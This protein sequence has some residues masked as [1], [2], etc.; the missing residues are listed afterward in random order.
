MKEVFRNIFYMSRR[1]KLPSAL[2]LI[3]LVIAYAAFYLLMTQVIYESTYNHSIKDYKRLYRMESDFVYNEW[4]FS[5]FVCRPFADALQRMPEVE[6]YSLVHGGSSNESFYTLD[7]LRHKG[8]TVHYAMSPA[9]NTALSTLSPKVLDGEI[10]WTDTNKGTLIIP[11]SVATDYFGTE[12]AKDKKMWLIQNE[13]PVSFKVRGV[14]EDFPENSELLRRIYYNIYDEDTLELNAGYKCIV[15]FKDVPTDKEMK[16]LSQSLKQAII[17]HVS[18]GLKKKGLESKIDTYI[19]EINKTNFRFVPLAE[20]YFENTSF[21]SSGVRGFKGMLYILV[22]TCLIVIIIAAINFLN[23]TLV[24]SPMRISSLNTR[25]VLGAS[26]RSLRRI[27]VGEGIVISLVAC[28]AAIILCGLIQ[29][30]PGANK[31]ADGNLSLLSHWSL[32]V[33]MLGLAI[34]VGVA[35][36]HYPSIYATSYPTAIVLKGS[37]GLT[38]RG[39]KLRQVLTVFQLCISMLMVIYVGILL[40]QTRFILQSEYGYNKDNV[41]STE[42]P[43]AYDYCAENDTVS[44]LLKR[45]PVV[46]DVAFSDNLLGATDGHG[47]LW[48]RSVEDST[49][50]YTLM[51]CSA[52][53]PSAMGIEI[54]EGRDF[55]SSD[56]AAIIINEAMQERY[57]W[58]KLGTVIS[59]GISDE[60]PD[61]AVVVGVS[62]DIRYGTTRIDNHAS[63]CLVYKKDYPYLANVNV[64]IKPG[65]NNETTKDEINKALTSRYDNQITPIHYFNDVL[66]GT[67]KNEFRYMNM[68]V[69]ICIICLIITLTGLFCLTMFE[70]EYRRKEIGIRKIMG[71]TPREIINMLCS[72]YAIYILIS[73]AIAAPLALYFGW[74]TLVKTFKQHTDIISLWWL[75]PLALLLVGGIML[76]TVLVKSWHTAHENP[77]NSI[78]SE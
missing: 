37:F 45:L 58:I 20:S 24:E 75:F 40:K 63:F 38:P 42:L 76:G 2:N 41:L 8:D 11:K 5:D 51:H 4:D 49:F 7:F 52:N 33:V 71:A 62:K 34:I 6:S 66:K 77:S 78:K 14:Y 70:T 12:K 56:T 43:Y 16:G 9:N 69:L 47:T 44:Q 17:A 27:F 68:M 13:E 10:E 57:K 72:R 3:G 31:L 18:D 53:F 59:T 25:L 39:Q 54:I 1:F 61:S 35:A 50:K 26:R 55:T 22:L 19:D 28:V 48:T 36:C 23:F 30:L 32:L 73:F 64:V 21:T 46:A 65:E 60:E 67:Y 74:F 29:L 15:K